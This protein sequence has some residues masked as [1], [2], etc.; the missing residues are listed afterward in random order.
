MS[1]HETLK[2]ILI[3]NE[4]SVTHF[5][6]DTVGKVT[7]GVG[8]MM[9]TAADAQGLS[10]VVRSSGEAASAQQIAVDFA[11]VK[12]QQSGMLALHYRQFT[13]LDMLDDAI[14]RLL[15]SDIARMETGV[16]ANFTGYDSY[17]G[18]AQDALLDM[19]FNLGVNGLVSHFPKLRAAAQALDWN[20]CAAE[21]HRNG[22]GE[23]RNQ[24][25]KA[26][27]LQAANS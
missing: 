13:T 21:C 7:V 8:H 24:K 27:F 16:R 1:G 23:E 2:Q 26:L 3:E 12:A 18:P 22:I 4:D 20:T 9:P 14:D 6:L 25:T 15:E 11:N 19:A 5:Y 17:P 10:M